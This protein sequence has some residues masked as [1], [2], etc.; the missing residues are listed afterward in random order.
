MRSG[1]LQ[2]SRPR[3]RP[4]SAAYLAAR[5]PVGRQVRAVRLSQWYMQTENI[6]CSVQLSA[7]VCSC[8]FVLPTYHHSMVPRYTYL[9]FILSEIKC[10]F[11]ITKT[12]F[13]IMTAVQSCTLEQFRLIML[14]ASV[15]PD[16][17]IKLLSVLL[18][19]GCACF[20]YQWI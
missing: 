13:F 4:P 12:V 14:V 2:P 8:W 3:P 19:F 11:H 16:F 10:S 9:P 15:Q 6:A 18:L 1:P 7:A 5:S 20:V 17:R